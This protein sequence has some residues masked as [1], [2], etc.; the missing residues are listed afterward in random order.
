ML[1]QGDFSA[2]LRCGHCRSVAR[3]RVANVTL[4]PRQD[5]RRPNREG[6]VW[7][8]AAECSGRLQQGGLWGSAGRS[9]RGRGGHVWQFATSRRQGRVSLEAVAEQEAPGS[10]LLS[11]GAVQ[12]HGPAGRR[13][14]GAG[15]SH[16]AARSPAARADHTTGGTTTNINQK[17]NVITSTGRTSRSAPTRPSI[18]I[19]PAALPRDQPCRGRRSLLSRRAR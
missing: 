17:S 2:H 16:R 15:R 14:Y 7:A 1:R 18:S 4:S 19:S 13:R 11:D 12:R 10:L 3:T 6:L 8:L 5:H 9:R